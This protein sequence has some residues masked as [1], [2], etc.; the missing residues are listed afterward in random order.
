MVDVALIVLAVAW[1]VAAGY[2]AVRAWRSGR[3]LRSTM[4]AGGEARLEALVALDRRRDR[5]AEKQ[6][7]VDA[8]LVSL[9]RDGG[10]CAARRAGAGD[11]RRCARPGP[12]RAMTRV[13]AADL[14]TNSTRLLVADVDAGGLVEVERLL[15]ITRLGAGVDRDRRLADAAMER[16]LDALRGYDVVARDAGAATPPG[17]RDQ[18]RPRQRERRRVRRAHP[19]RDRLPDPC[20]SA[21]RGGAADLPRRDCRAPAAR[22]RTTRSSTS[23]AARPSSRPATPAGSPRTCRSTPAACARPSAGWARRRRSPRR[24]RR[25]APPLARACSPP[26]CPTPGATSTADRRGGHGDDAGGAR[27]RP[28]ALRPRAHPRPRPATRG[29]RDLARAP[30]AADGRAARAPSAAWSPAVRRSS[31]AASLCCWRRIDRARARPRRGL[32]ARHPARHRAAGRRI[33][34][35]ARPGWRNW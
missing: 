6:S 30:G 23:A 13:A 21:A 33:C 11:P 18:R 25:P 26:P 4:A 35:G 10:R 1:L 32:R 2:G 28:R 14:G 24:S 8:N 34:F 22:G 27:P 12:P 29:G 16:T 20:S 3:R 5:L 15:T 9:A 17:D 31:S 19:G 7:V